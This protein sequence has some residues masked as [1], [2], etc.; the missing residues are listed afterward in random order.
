[1]C[2]R[3]AR[4]VARVPGGRRHVRRAGIG[5][6][7]EPTGEP[8]AEAVAPEAAGQKRVSLTGPLLWIG[9]PVLLLMIGGLVL[10]LVLLARRTGHKSPGPGRYGKKMD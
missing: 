8:S 10:V 4:R 9:G 6:P 3:A 5:E 1:M 2:Q 7:T